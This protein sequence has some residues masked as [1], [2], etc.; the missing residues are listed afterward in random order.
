MAALSAGHFAAVGPEM[1]AWCT[2]QTGDAWR[3][4]PAT[5]TGRCNESIGALAH[6]EHLEATT[7]RCC[8]CSDGRHTLHCYTYY[9]SYHPSYNVPL[10]ALHACHEGG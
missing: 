4:C 1:A 3:W 7:S 10:L 5:G 9:V 6:T 2:Q 8:T